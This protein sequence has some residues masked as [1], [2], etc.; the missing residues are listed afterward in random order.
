MF[1]RRLSTISHRVATA[2]IFPVAGYLTHVH[3]NILKAVLPS[4]PLGAVC[5]VQRRCGPPLKAEVVGIAD[6]VVSLSPCGGTE[7]L[8][9][10]AC[11]TVV[12]TELRLPLC[13][14]LKG[15]VVD[16][17]LSP[18]DGKGQIT[19]QLTL[20]PVRRTSSPPMSRP[21]ISKP[22]VTGIRAIDGLTTLGTGQ[23]ISLFGSPGTGKTSMIGMLSQHCKADITV[24][25]LVG[26]RGR[27]VREFVDDVLPA[28]LR[29][30]AVVVAA[31]SERPAMERATC[32]LTATTVAE[33]FRDRGNNVFL[34]IDSLTRTA[35]ALREI[36]L[37]AGEAPTRRGYPA[38]VYPALPA[39]IERAGRN[40]SG[41]ITAIYTVLTEGEIQADPIA[42]EVKSLTD[43]HLVLSR[44]LARKAH[45]PAFDMSESLSRLM[46]RIA[47]PAHRDAAD[48]IRRLLAK[49]DEIEMLLQVGEYTEG[50]DPEADHAI[51]ARESIRAF[52]MQRSDEDS[53]FQL[54]LQRLQGL[55][56]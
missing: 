53:K 3:T 36:G 54:T 51:A 55:V 31:T 27:E 47:E 2:G 32:A 23:R 14:G 26:E 37:A 16:A 33:Y 35:R 4:A 40:K 9:E 44:D 8:V 18:I 50:T 46:A 30:R 38:S 56:A 25:G 29:K 1:A 10:G 49:Y 12:D 34:L 13:K 15:R 42:E 6:G 39:I 19:G 5:A 45:F 20:L 41:S 28:K 17:F 43:G 24:I 7:G 21:L 22:F 52:L 11:V 48:L